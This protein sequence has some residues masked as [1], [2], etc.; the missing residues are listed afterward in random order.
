VAGFVAPAGWGVTAVAA[1]AK[2][3]AGFG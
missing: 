1:I 2:L 3:E